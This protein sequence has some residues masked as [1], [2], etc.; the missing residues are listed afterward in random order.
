MEVTGLK[1]LNRAL[2]KL[3]GR[4]H[5]NIM[6]AAVRAGANIVKEEAARNLDGKKKDIVVAK[7]RA[8]KGT[9]LFK[10]GPSSGKWYLKFKE[11]GTKPHVIKSKKKALADG[12]EF[13]GLVV[14]HPGQPAAPFLRPALDENVPK[15][16]E[17]MAKKTRERLEKEA[18]KR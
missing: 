6:T 9:T 1:E 4:I 13:F 3:P 12:T 5:N 2:S 14:D 7:S 15:I 18:A 10:I 17:A 8:P 16:V 11:T